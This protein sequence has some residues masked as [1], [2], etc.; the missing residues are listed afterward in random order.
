MKRIFAVSLVASVFGLLTSCGSH[1]AAKSSKLADTSSADPIEFDGVDADSVYNALASMGVVDTDRLIGATNL[2]VTSLR[3]DRPL[4][5][6]HSP[7][8]CRLT[9][10]NATTG[11]AETLT[12]AGKDAATILNILSLHGASVNGGINASAV[13]AKSLTCS[14]PV[15][16][17]PT[18]TC[19]LE[20]L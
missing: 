14:M 18:A 15:I 7:V 8:N 3:C 19:V 5:D 17:N 9:T 6:F 2:R 4:Y 1:E 13:A 12:H 11:A 20:T 16:P 10:K